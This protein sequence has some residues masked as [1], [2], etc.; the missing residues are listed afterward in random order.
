MTSEIIQ[1]ILRWILLMAIQI[2]VFNNI[3]IGGVYN[4]FIYVLIILSL[5]IEA[6]ALVTLLIGFFTGFILDVFSHTY[7]LHTMAFTLFGFLRPIV[8]RLVAP[9][10][11]YAFGSNAN[12]LDMQLGRYS[13]YALLLIFSHHLLLFVLE[14]FSGG[15]VGSITMKVLVNTFLTFIVVL[16]SQSFTRKRA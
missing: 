16:V 12:V 7:G 13:A 6:S 3:Y 15:S 1:N 8:L 5:P 11:G 4:P 2:L 9:R 10:D 14:G